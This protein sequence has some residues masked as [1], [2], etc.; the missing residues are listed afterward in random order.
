MKGHIDMIRERERVRG[1]EKE[2]DRE[3]ERERE[4]ERK[5]MFRQ[6]R[7]LREEAERKKAEDDSIKFETIRPGDA[8]H[9]P[10]KYDSVAV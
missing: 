2:K 6:A 5:T 3:R 8:T 4:R 9:Y 10:K 1:R 7:E